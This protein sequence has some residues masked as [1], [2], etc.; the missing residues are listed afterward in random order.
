MACGT[1]VVTTQASSLPEIVGDAAFTVD[2]DDA[3]GMA[4]AII[5]VLIEDN[6]ADDLRKR[7]PVQAR[8]FSWEKTATETLL[9]YD[10]AAN[11]P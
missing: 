3:R 2:P 10:A 6:L 9:V 1:P 7:G 8:Q 5:S 4:G 11:S